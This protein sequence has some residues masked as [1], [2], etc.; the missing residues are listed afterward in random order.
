MRIL[1]IDPGSRVSGYGI[2][3]VQRSD[4]HFVTCGDIRTTSGQMS[5]RLEEI[6]AGISEL[7]ERYTV[8]AAAIE[9][10]FIGKNASSAIKVGQASGAAIA[11]VA[12]LGIEVTEYAPRDVKQSVV[13]TGTATKEQVQF[14]VRE[15][16][17]LD[18]PPTKDAADA[19]AVAITHGQQIDL[20]H[21]LEVL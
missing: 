11:T 9:R 19:L 18:S 8:S 14:M 2:V 3:D 12:A 15:L 6:S 16:L 20:L 7:M 10:P 5:V 17:Q 4:L 1:G 13:G 21:Q